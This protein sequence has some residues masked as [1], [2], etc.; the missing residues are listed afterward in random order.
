MST[1]TVLQPNSTRAIHA[2][3]LPTRSSSALPQCHISSSKEL[4][5]GGLNGRIYGILRDPA[6]SQYQDRENPMTRARRFVGR[7]EVYEI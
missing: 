4:R 7:A 3:V 1:H 6:C 5:I 2:V